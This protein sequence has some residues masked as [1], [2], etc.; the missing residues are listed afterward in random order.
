MFVKNITNSMDSHNGK[1]NK[2]KEERD[3]NGKK[4]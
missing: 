3:H 2:K 4:K 1:T